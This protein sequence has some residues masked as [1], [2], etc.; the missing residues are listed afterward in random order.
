MAIFVPAIVAAAVIRLSA[1]HPSTRPRPELAKAIEHPPLRQAPRTSLSSTESAAAEPV[2]ENPPVA[3]AN[4]FDRS[5][6]FE[7]PPGT[8]RVEARDAVAQILLARA[9]ERQNRIKAAVE[10][11]SR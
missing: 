10:P 3:F 11:R 4:P 9:R 5:E 2:I 7:F 1:S 6:V 8:T